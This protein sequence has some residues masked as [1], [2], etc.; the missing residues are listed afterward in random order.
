MAQQKIT[1]ADIELV[2]YEFL[3]QSGVDQEQARTMARA[4]AVRYGSMARQAA[5]FVKQ[6][7]A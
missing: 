1:P 3:T 6:G 7:V 5:Y 4:G 2:I